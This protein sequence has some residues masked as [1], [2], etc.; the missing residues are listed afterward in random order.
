MGDRY[1]LTVKCPSCDTIDEDVYY[2]PT[3]DFVSHTCS[4]CGAR[5]DLAEYTGISYEDASTQI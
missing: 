5:I 4:K 2:A 3:C 1:F